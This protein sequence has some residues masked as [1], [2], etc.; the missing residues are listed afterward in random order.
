MLDFVQHQSNS[1]QLRKAPI[2]SL[3]IFNNLMTGMRK[4][5]KIRRN[6]SKMRPDTHL[7]KYQAIKR[8]K[9]KITIKTSLLIKTLAWLKNR[10]KQKLRGK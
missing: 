2:V 9:R 5:L 6:K 10:S 1:I 3:L 8:M 7:R 4:K